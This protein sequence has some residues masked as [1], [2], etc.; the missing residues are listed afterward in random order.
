VFV[1]Q[2][3]ARRNCTTGGA[4]GRV[5]NVKSPLD[6]ALGAVTNAWK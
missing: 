3:G 2:A 5:E 4:T 1:S 6:H